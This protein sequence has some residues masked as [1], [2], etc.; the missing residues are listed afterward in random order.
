MTRLISTFTISACLLVGCQD[1]TGPDTLR[2]A[3][4]VKIEDWILQDGPLSIS[5]ETDPD[6]TREERIAQSGRM[7]EAQQKVLIALEGTSTPHSAEQRVDE[8]L[9]ELQGDQKIVAS[10]VGSIAVLKMALTVEPT[11]ED[12]MTA[13]REL[14]QRHLENLSEHRSQQLSTVADVMDRLA[15][16]DPEAN[17]SDLAHT[18]IADLDERAEADL[19]AIKQR[20]GIQDEE[21]SASSRGPVPEAVRR[22]AHHL[23]N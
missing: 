9:Q 16:I 3:S 11:T 17:L 19:A 2:P 21:P 14:L 7:V 13:H 10:Q 6:A 4:E 23:E 20:F 22:I 1:A 8:L 15:D 12:E 18:F 5:L